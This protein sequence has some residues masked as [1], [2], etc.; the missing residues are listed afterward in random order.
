MLKQLPSET[1][2]EA[3]ERRISELEDECFDAVEEGERWQMC[4]W[5]AVA[6]ALCHAAVAAVA[7]YGADTNALYA[8]NL[9]MAFLL[10]V[11]GIV[12]LERL[13]AAR[14]RYEHACEQTTKIIAWAGKGGE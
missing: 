11:V 6:A 2:G 14:R 3:L 7:L 1:V 5:V 10:I 12:A 9:G 13:I 4:V 8:V